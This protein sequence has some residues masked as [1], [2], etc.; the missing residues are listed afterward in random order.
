MVQ[1]QAEYEKGWAHTEAHLQPA[2]ETYPKNP[3]GP[4]ELLPVPRKTWPHRHDV[5]YHYA[6]PVIG[7]KLSGR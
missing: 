4:D 3:L 7:A 6:H 1:W 2:V 5:P